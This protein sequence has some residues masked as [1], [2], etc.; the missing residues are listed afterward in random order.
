MA[1][2]NRLKTMKSAPVGTIMPWSG[3][4]SDGDLPNNIP[5]GW[6]VCDG[7]TFPANTF[8]LLASMIGNTYGPTDDSIVGNFPDYDDGDTFRVP[9]MNGRAM[10]DLE[11]S[12]LQ[13][14]KYQ[15]CLLYTSPSPRDTILSRMPSSA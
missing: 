13:E 8:P 4:S 9:N 3:Q 10:V 1:F 11:K 6:I 7:R 15:F 5:T 14:D 2:Y 12:Y